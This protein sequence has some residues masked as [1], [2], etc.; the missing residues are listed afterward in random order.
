MF[1]YILDSDGD[2]LRKQVKPR[3]DQENIAFFFFL[4]ENANMGTK[5]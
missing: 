1:S 3:N 5:F 2:F 4:L